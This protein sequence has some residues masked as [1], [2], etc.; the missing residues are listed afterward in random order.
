MVSAPFLSCFPGM[1]CKSDHIPG[2]RGD[3]YGSVSAV[4]SSGPRVRLISPPTRQKEIFVLL[5]RH[6]YS[7]GSRGQPKL[8]ALCLDFFFS[9]PIASR[10]ADGVRY[11]LRVRALGGNRSGELALCRRR[12]FGGRRHGSAARKRTRLRKL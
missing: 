6:G 8:L 10:V 12:T 4:S 7:V 1:C 2:T 3:S 9:R 5:P 11:G